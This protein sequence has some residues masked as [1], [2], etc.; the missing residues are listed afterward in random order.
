MN[1][2][3]TLFSFSFAEYMTVVKY[4]DYIKYP[5]KSPRYTITNI[6]IYYNTYNYTFH[7]VFFKICSFTD[8]DPIIHYRKIIDLSL[9]M[10]CL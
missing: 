10:P 2:R 5:I 9:D 1:S 8:T 7:H 3:E 6:Y 4:A